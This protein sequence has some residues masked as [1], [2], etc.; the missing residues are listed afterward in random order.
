MKAAQLVFAQ[1]PWRWRLARARNIL[2][3]MGLA[4][5]YVFRNGVSWRSWQRHRRERQR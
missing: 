2:A 4:L 1:S 3:L 5:V